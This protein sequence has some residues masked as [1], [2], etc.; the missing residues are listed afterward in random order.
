LEAHRVFELARK[1]EAASAYLDASVFSSLFT[2][3]AEEGLGKL[4]LKTLSKMR[5]MGFHPTRQNLCCLMEAI[6]KT[7]GDEGQMEQ[8]LEVEETVFDP[9][10]MEKHCFGSVL[11]AAYSRLSAKF[12]TV[13][14]CLRVMRAM[15]K[16]KTL[17]KFVFTQTLTAFAEQKQVSQMA[18]LSSKGMS[19]FNFAND[20]RVFLAM[21]KGLHIFEIVV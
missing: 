16:A 10:W 3:C 7:K 14:S 4:C 19:E 11:L 1:S 21:M 8:M 12:N 13:E 15:Q 2:A 20:S 5:K 9:F 17:D 6:S 18:E